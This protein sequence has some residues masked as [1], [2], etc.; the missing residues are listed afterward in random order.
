VCPGERNPLDWGGG[1]VSSF[2][3]P[4]RGSDNGRFLKE[5][6]GDGRTKRSTMG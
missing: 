1:L 2:Y 4:R 5:P 3:R 6:P